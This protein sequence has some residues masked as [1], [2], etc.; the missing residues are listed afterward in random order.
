MQ[1]RNDF[2]AE[3]TCVFSYIRLFTTLTDREEARLEA[4]NTAIEVL[5]ANLDYYM[6]K[7][8]IPLDT[9]PISAADLQRS[10]TTLRYSGQSQ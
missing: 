9:S 2:S 7:N 4:F 3:L 1:S 8:N 5:H 6:E 10:S